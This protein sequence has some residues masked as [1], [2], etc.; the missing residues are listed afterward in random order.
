M[1]RG[2]LSNG[3]LAAEAMP[4]LLHLSLV[5]VHCEQRGN[6]VLDVAEGD[7]SS[8]ATPRVRYPRRGC[9]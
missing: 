7:P 6:A 1:R 5:P 4:S 2:E 3:L 8:A 9:P